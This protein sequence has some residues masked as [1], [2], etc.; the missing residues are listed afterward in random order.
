LCEKI[1]QR[2]LRCG[3]RKITYIELLH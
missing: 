3:E 2:I 1:V